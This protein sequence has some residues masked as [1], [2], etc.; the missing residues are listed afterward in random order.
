[1]LDHQ[2]IFFPEPWQD[3]N[4]QEISGLPLEEV[5]FKTEDGVRLFGWYLQ[6]QEAIGTLLWSHGNAGNIIHR[7]ENLEFLYRHGFSVFIFDYRG[8]GK[9]EGVPTEAGFYQDVEAAWVYLTQER[10]LSAEQIVAYGR[11]LGAAVAGELA[12]K[13]PVAGLILECPFPS[14]EVVAKRLFMGLPA[15]RM[16]ASRF[17]L[18]KRLKVVEVPVLVLHGDGDKVISFDLGE[19]VYRAAKEPKRFYRIVGADH[20]D[21]YQVGGE[22]YFETLTQ[23]VREAT[24]NSSK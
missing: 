21:T 10:K 4:W 15:H 20:N 22:G 23:F 2:Y 16:V 11:S 24:Q 9:S 7:L 12:V 5:W 18:A 17:D 19:A 3:G 14:V 8:Y 1:M 13:R 6:A